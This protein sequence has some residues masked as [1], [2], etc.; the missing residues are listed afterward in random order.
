MEVFWTTKAKERLKDLH[1]FY[2]RIDSEKYAN[3]IKNTLIARTVLLGKFPLRGA[4]DQS[5]ELEDLNLRFLAEENCKLFY[6]VSD[7]KIEV[8]SVFDVRLN[9]DK[10]SI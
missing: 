1:S 5:E 2:R 6:R 8:V 3:R 4:L 9:P 10:M 7:N